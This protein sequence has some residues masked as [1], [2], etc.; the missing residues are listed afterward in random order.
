MRRPDY[1]RTAGRT[2]PGV[3]P[4]VVREPPRIGLTT[5]RERASWGVWD[6]PADLL[7]V[8]Y[9]DVIQEA[10]G[11]ALLLPP[12]GRDLHATAQ[13]TI[14][15]LHGLL[16]AGGA[17][18]DPGRYGAAREAPTGAARP[19]RDAWE[20]VLAD[21]ALRRGLPVLGV[22]RGLQVLNVLL[23]GTLVQHLPDRVGHDGHCP[24]LGVHGRHAVRVAEGTRLGAILGASADVATHH[25]QAVDTL[26]A[27][28]IPTAWTDDGAIEAAELPDATWV[29]G[30]QWHPE[31]HDRDPLFAAF[32]G[33]CAAWRDTGSTAD[34]RLDPAAS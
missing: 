13:A 24:V 11:V 21:T 28:L 20:L 10:G 12:G 18:L 22:C 3:Q 1:E 26:G 8:S 25:H 5:Y 6:E 19:D 30:V 4:A 32:A 14:D 31:V 34:P 16:I 7:P 2:I 29:M 9:S 33:A 27:G 15:G 17:D 23:G